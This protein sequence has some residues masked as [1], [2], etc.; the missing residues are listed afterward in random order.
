M[1][2]VYS[3]MASKVVSGPPIPLHIVEDHNEALEHI[4]NAIGAKR[5]PFTGICFVHFDSHPD[6]LSPDLSV[7]HIYDKETLL[8]AVSIADWILPAVYAGHFECVVWLKPPWACQIQDGR[9]TLI[10]GKH[11]VNNKIRSKNYH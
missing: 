7:D 5:L 6:L 2:E 9:H 1:I 10:V 8:D 4:Y 11:R 3:D